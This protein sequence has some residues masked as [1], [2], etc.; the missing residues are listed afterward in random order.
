MAW[1]A[2]LKFKIQLDWVTWVIIK[3]TFTIV[4]RQPHSEIDIPGVSKNRL[5]NAGITIRWVQSITIDIILFYY[6]LDP[7]PVRLQV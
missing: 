4:S 5:F 2:F 3:K 7:K 1:S 6:F